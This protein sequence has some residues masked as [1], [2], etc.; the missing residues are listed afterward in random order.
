MTNTCAV[1]DQ[2]PLTIAQPPSS[3]RLCNIE[4]GSLQTWRAHV[5]SNRHVYNL[6]LKVAQPGSAIL[7][8]PPPSTPSNQRK[9]AAPSCAGKRTELDVGPDQD[10]N[11]DSDTE[12]EPSVV[13][14]NPGKCLFC[15]Q[16]SST[17]DD[18]M[19]HMAA[20]HGFSVPFPEFLAVN[21]ETVVSYLHLLIFGYRKCICCCTQR[22][23]VKGVQQHMA[24][25]GHCRFDI[26]PDTEEFYKIPQSHSQNA[27]IEQMQ[28]DS[29]MPVR[30]PSGKLIAH[31]KN[32]DINERR[33]ARRG[34][35]DRDLD[36]FALGSGTS[37]PGSRA[38]S[39]P[40]LEVAERRRGNGGGEIVHRSEA[41]LAAQLSKLQIAGDRAQYKENKKRGR[42]DRGS[43]TLLF[44]HFRLDSGDS[45]FGRQF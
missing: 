29:S 42:L 6:Q 26:T 39:T 35:P 33:A 30:L 1:S 27:V 13:D 10:S 37:R 2:L 16:A 4:L 14:F 34:P 3:C 8:Q 28:R 23:T 18:N 19:T 12:D 36:S 31:R 7:L 17:S 25:K 40:G 5:K 9:R 24:S 21:P 22:S 20:A 43:N 38:P 41:I 11:T 44:K 45:R 32:L 15:V